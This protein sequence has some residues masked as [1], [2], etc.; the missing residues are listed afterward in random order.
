MEG[1]IMPEGSLPGATAA[2]RDQLYEEHR[3]I[4]P[5]AVAGTYRRLKWI[6]MAVLLGIYYLVPWLRWD[7]GPDAPSQ[8]VL[9]DLDQGRLFFFF[10]EI[11]PQEVYY[12]TGLLIMAAVGLFLATTLAGRVWCGYA[13]PQTVWTDLFVWV[14][15]L[16]EGDRAERMRLD[17]SRWNAAKLRRKVGKHAVWL[18]ISL[19]TGGAWIMYFVD[20]PTLVRDI[21]HFSVP[22]E[23]LVFIGLLTSTTYLL[24]GWAREQVCAYMCPWPRIQAAMLDED[25][26]IVTYQGWR[27]ERRGP[28]RKSETW[29][30]H[31]KRGYGDCIDC[32]QCVQVCPVGI[33]IRTDSQSDCINCGLCIDACDTMMNKIGRPTGLITYDTLTNQAARAVGKPTGWR[34]L[35]PRTIVYSLMLVVIAGVMTGGLI[36]R[37][38]LEISVL[39]D[40]APL[41]VTLS[42][43][44]IRNGYTF[45]I[46]NMTRRAKDYVLDLKGLSGAHL[47]VVGQE[48]TAGSVHL[49]AA[50]DAVA[51]YRV[52][53]QAPRGDLTA[54]SMP[55]SFI[56]TDSGGGEKADYQSVFIGP[57]R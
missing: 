5:K 21:A 13:C 50:P 30:Q 19:F 40:R 47:S 32:I 48:N 43:G 2:S 57:E 27:G 9:V 3:K 34:L 18:L 14:E 45:K 35:R 44:S 10:I 20:A 52:Y 29:E 4:H 11:W 23:A 22:I 28:K 54:V 31:F 25:S 12:L 46:S 1:G 6:L 15:R 42:D 41:F 56:L 55:V 53:V 33:D 17:K 16:F 39:R 51:T 38:R 49:S 36:L 7:R 24:A 26:L 8:A 37:P